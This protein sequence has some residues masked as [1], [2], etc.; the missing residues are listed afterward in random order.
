M[1][2][3]I[4]MQTR[5]TVAGRAFPLQALP[6]LLFHSRLR[7][8]DGIQEARAKGAR[9]CD[10]R[11]HRL[12]SDRRRR[13][14]GDFR[15]DAAQ[16]YRIC[17]P[18]W[19]SPCATGLGPAGRAPADAESHFYRHVWKGL[20]FFYDVPTGEPYTCVHMRAKPVGVTEKSLQEALG[21]CMHE[22]RDHPKARRHARGTVGG[23]RRTLSD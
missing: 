14:R 17:F 12:K 1:R 5:R 21:P 4:G 15:N 22:N 10:A 19:R 18:N 8:A 2:S 6:Q 20:T 7:A 9:G 13:R 16:R 23:R 3:P 11:G